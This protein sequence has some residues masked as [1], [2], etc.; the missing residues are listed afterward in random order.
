MAYE[1]ILNPATADSKPGDVYSLGKT[2]WCLATDVNWPPLGHQPA[3]T[4]GYSI[5]DLR[6][7]GGARE[8]DGL[9]D[10]MTR[11]DPVHD[12]RCGRSQPTSPAGLSLARER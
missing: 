2:L 1:M 6:P 4:Q 10:R 9:V 3:G 8:L 5:G 12:P 7:H 11:L